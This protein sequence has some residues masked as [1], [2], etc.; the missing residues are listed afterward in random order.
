MWNED[1]DQLGKNLDIFDF[2]GLEQDVMFIRVE[3]LEADGGLASGVGAGA[4]FS[5][6]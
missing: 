5:L 2:S 3:G 1:I 4:E 6:W